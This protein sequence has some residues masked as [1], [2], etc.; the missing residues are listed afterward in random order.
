VDSAARED[1]A[2]RIIALSNADETE[3]IVAAVDSG[4]TRF[5]HN[6]I[7]Q[8][9]WTSDA[10]VRVRA[11]VDGCTGV[12]TSNDLGE[13]AL[14]RTTARA[15][16]L[17][18]F[19]PR[20]DARAPIGG[21]PPAAPAR[22]AFVAAT[23]A[24]AAEQRAHVAS[25]VFDVAERHD[26]WAAGFVT[27]SETGTTIANS[28]GTLASFDATDCGLAVKQNGPTSSGYAERFSADVGDLDGTAIAEIAATKALRSAEPVEVEAA[29]WTVILEPPAA[30]ELFAFMASHF[31][32]QSYDEG[33][34]FLS[35]RLGDR[36]T[37]ANVTIVDDVRHELAP[38]MPFDFEGFP[39]RRVALLDRGIA[40]GIV[41]DA[42]WARRLGREN[43]GHALPAP[44]SEGPL[45][46]HLVVMPG[47][48]SLDELIAQTERGLLISRLWY[49][50]TVDERQTIVTGMTRDGTFLIEDG[51]LARGVRNMRFN[52]S[53][54]EAL[55]AAQ[56]AGELV[57]A[58]AYSYSIVL[59]AVKFERFTFTSATDF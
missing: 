43:T 18:R 16:E 23:A 9:V 49:V 7:H 38:G 39:T 14:R 8:N 2:A 15:T 26:L 46:S 37:P 4:L 27:T 36:F 51:R 53:I 57:R 10:V 35:G 44:N 22:G 56:F 33:S 3:V 48:R 28:S 55:G 20:D 1:L 52:Q 17:A 6:A 34:S 31:S 21:A 40:G 42:T 59:P 30:G 29:D 47:E 24:A 50:R 41:T 12:A 32:A 19:A 5:T 13:D 45:P 54:L 58:A 11:V 25:C